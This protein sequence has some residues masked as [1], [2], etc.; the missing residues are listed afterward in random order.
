M[1][2]KSLLC[3]RLSQFIFHVFMVFRLLLSPPLSLS[4][5]LSFIL[6]CPKCTYWFSILFFLL[7]LSPRRLYLSNLLDAQG[8]LLFL[9]TTCFST[10]FPHVLCSPTPFSVWELVFD[11]IVTF[12]Y[13]SHVHTYIDKSAFSRTS[14]LDDQWK[15]VKM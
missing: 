15:R 14:C 1:P 9:T 12:M 11:H 4:L 10:Y 5:S 7:Y 13:I 8:L 2:F 6:S 3:V